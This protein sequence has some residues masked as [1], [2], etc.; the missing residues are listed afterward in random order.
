MLSIKNASLYADF[1]FSPP[2]FLITCDSLRPDL[3]LV[4]TNC[5]FESNIKVNSDRKAAKCRPL[6]MNLRIEYTN[7]NFV[8]FSMS[9]LGILVRLQMPLCKC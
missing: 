3:V 5:C 6:L 4:G 2:P 7:N 8:T 1:P 9:A